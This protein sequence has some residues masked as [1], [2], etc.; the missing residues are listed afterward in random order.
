MRFSFAI[1]TL[2][3]IFGL[4]VLVPQQ[5]YALSISIPGSGFFSN[6]FKWPS[7]PTSPP[8]P[9]YQPRSQATP[10]SSPPISPSPKISPSPT[11]KV[12]PSI[13]PSPTPISTTNPSTDKKTFIMNAINS[14]RKSQG[15]VEVKTDPKT[16][17]FAKIR[18]Q[19]SSS[20]FNHDG[21]SNRINSKTLPYP[22]YHYVT[23]NIAMTSNYK[24]VV[25]MW[26]NSTGHAKNMRTDTPF[27]CV[28][29]YG[30]Y[31]AYEGWKP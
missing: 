19:E 4:F 6:S 30:N 27:V 15:L 26:I 28:E 23:E 13:K 17:N 29:N 7:P 22:S 20:G 5:V 18:A 10:N 25:N 24:D 16:C 14:Y 9:T 12:T 8:I 11:P 31:Y 3:A 2:V 1:L 21:F